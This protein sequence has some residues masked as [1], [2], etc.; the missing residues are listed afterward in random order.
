MVM[1][2]DSKLS[3]V[4]SAVAALLVAGCASGGKRTA[5]PQRPAAAP[6]PAPPQAASRAVAPINRG[7]SDAESLWHVRSALN[8]AALSCRGPN[9]ANVVPA[10]NRLLRHHK[11]PL[12]SAYA[13]TEAKFRARHGGAWAKHYDTH[14]T[15]L[16][17]FFAMPTAQASFCRTSTSVL[18]SANGM[19]AGALVAYAPSALAQLEAPF[20]S[21]GPAV[22]ARRAPRAR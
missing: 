18:A 14:A 6:E 20:M 15:R 10:Y 17:N 1:R 21:R 22:V 5:A 19:T 11:A 3:I 7:L 8:V 4:A 9:R 16:Y 2:V 12:A 13:A